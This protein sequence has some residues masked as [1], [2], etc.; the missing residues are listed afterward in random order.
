MKTIKQSPTE[1][2]T[3]A[4]WWNQYMLMQLGLTALMCVAKTGDENVFE[5]LLEN[6]ADAMKKDCVSSVERNCCFCQCS[7]GF[8]CVETVLF[9]FAWVWL[10]HSVTIQLGT[11]YE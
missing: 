9:R 2:V 11:H 10:Y 4:D 8:S 1:V 5:L 7:C 3:D 6:N